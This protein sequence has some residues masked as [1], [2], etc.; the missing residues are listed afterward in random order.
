VQWQ[1][2]IDINR[3]I[4]GGQ[5]VAIFALLTVRAIAQVRAETRGSTR[6]PAALRRMVRMRQGRT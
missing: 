2:A 4:L 6:P 5:I 3:V 1:P